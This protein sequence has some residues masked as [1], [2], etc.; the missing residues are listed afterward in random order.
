MAW[1]ASLIADFRTALIGWSS[2]RGG[3]RAAW[4]DGLELLRQREI[5]VDTRVGSQVVLRTRVRLTGDAQTDIVRSW[6]NTAATGTGIRDT[7]NFHFGSVAAAVRGWAVLAAQIRL[8]SDVLVVV[9]SFT[10]LTSGWRN[11]QTFELDAL[12]GL[13]LSQGW[14]VGAVTALVGLGIRFAVRFLLRL[15]FRRSLAAVQGQR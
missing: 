7:A 10:A 8:I 2:A 13:L 6:L 3:W 9:G 4:R 11:L 12:L 1:P 14:L 5:T 15:Y